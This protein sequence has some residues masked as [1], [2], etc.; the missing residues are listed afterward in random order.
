MLVS[1][2]VLSEV[3][4][5]ARIMSISAIISTGCVAILLSTSITGRALADSQIPSQFHGLWQ[6]TTE[7]QPPTCL[8]IDSDIRM[9]VRADRI[10]LHEGLCIAQSADQR[11]ENTLLFTAQC[12]EEGTS[13]DSNEEWSLENRGQHTFLTIRGLNASKPYNV[14]Y[15]LCP[16]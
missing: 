3:H 5:S 11:D 7:H 15:G 16:R 12:K 10:D 1:S 4:W 2:E 9:T 6:I 13:W 14:I 8:E